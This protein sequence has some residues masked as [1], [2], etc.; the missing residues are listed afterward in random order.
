MKTL[1]ETDKVHNPKN[2]EILHPEIKYIVDIGSNLPSYDPENF[3]RIKY[4]K[5]ST[6]SKIIPDNITIRK[7][8]SLISELQ[9]GLIKDKEFIVVHCHYGFNRT[10]FLI[11]SYLIEKLGWSVSDAIESFKLAKEPGI[12]HPHFIDGLYL[13]YEN[14]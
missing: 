12:K 2:F 6:V 8:I 9:N 7:F 11:C 4:I 14:N 13:R 3:Q 10:G 5:F 1:R